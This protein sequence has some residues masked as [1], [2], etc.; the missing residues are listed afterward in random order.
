MGTTTEVDGYV[1]RER[2]RVSGSFLNDYAKMEAP[3]IKVGK[4]HRE[5]LAPASRNVLFATRMVSDGIQPVCIP[6]SLH[7]PVIE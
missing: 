6:V 2:S 1:W 3:V 7:W 5:L 4:I